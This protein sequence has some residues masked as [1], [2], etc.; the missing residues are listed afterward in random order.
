MNARLVLIAVALA[1]T[2]CVSATTTDKPAAGHSPEES[3]I[4]SSSLGPGDL[5]VAQTARYREPFDITY[6]H[7]EGT[8]SWRLTFSEIKCGGS[9]ILNRAILAKAYVAVPQPDAGMQFCLLEF[10]VTNEGNANDV[11]TASSASVNVGMK[12]YLGEHIGGP[13]ADVESAYN[14]YAN[15]SSDDSASGLN[16]D[17]SEVSWG[18]FEIP[19]AATAT[20]VSVPLGTSLQQVGGV[21][22]VLIELEGSAGGSR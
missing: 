11:W 17:A 12:A 6:T 19:A 10:N 15:P 22:Q 14:A 5:P 20:S 1:V 9:E 8:S 13:L 7:V 2:G 4:A 21:D 3:P 16:P 18:V